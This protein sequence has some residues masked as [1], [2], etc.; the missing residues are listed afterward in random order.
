MDVVKGFI[1]CRC[2]I[3]NVA[4]ERLLVRATEFGG[5]DVLAGDLTD[6]VGAGN[7]HFGS[8]FHG[9]NKVRGHRGVHRTT[10]AF[11]K[12]DGDLRASAR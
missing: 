11:A 7:V 2:H 10:S 8:A 9:N 1:L 12:H 6:D 5:G 4:V 3:G